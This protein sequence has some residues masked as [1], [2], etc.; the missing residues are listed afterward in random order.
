MHRGGKGENKRRGKRENSVLEYIIN[1]GRISR[2]TAKYFSIFVTEHRRTTARKKRK[3]AAVKSLSLNGRSLVDHNSQKLALERGVSHGRLPLDEHVDMKTRKVLT[4]DHVSATASGSFCNYLRTFLQSLLRKQTHSLKELSTGDIERRS[5]AINQEIFAAFDERLQATKTK[6]KELLSS[7]LQLNSENGDSPGP[8]SDSPVTAEFFAALERAQQIHQK[9]RQLL[10]YA[11]QTT[12]L[13]IMEQMS[14]YQEA[15]LERLYRWTQAQCRNTEASESNQL[16]TKAIGWLQDRPVLLKYVVDEYCTA[17]R[18]I[19]VRSFLD[20]LTG[21]GS[22]GSRPMELH[23]HDPPRY[24]GDMLAWLHQMVPTEK[25]NVVALLKGCDKSDVSEL[26]ASTLSS[27]TEGVC[28]PLRVRVEQVISSETNA[29]VLHTLSSLLSFYHKT[30][31]Q[32]MTEGS[33]METLCDLQTQ[34]H[35]AFLSA[36]EMSVHRI[37]ERMQSPAQDLGPSPCIGQ[38]LNL[39]RDILTEKRIVE[40]QAKEVGE[41]V[42]RILNP[43]LETLTESASR[44]PR[45]DQATYML[46]SL[47]QIHSSLAM[48]EFVD[49]RI[50]SLK[51]MID[52]N[53]AILCGEQ[54]SSLIHSLGLGPICS[55]LQTRAGEPLANVPGMDPDSLTSFL[56]KFDGLLAAPDILQLSQWRLLISGNHRK[57]VQRR[58]LDAVLNV[59]R[60]LYQAVHDPAN[61]YPNPALL[62]SR[63]PAQVEALLS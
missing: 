35:R 21:G 19:V 50:E 57:L 22:Y 42:D 53:L 38:M 25:E 52:D 58:A 17:R 5:L 20:A 32:V 4:I 18:A 44:I 12:A 62:M 13:N 51:G 27:I 10:Q 45:V 7:M 3:N 14:L 9:C 56:M 23:A 16:L 36:L 61:N 24:V 55:L 46:N 15:A 31:N 40:I 6:T 33:L 11:P 43:L 28:R 37:M 59:Y 34:C 49:Q 29:A 54:A 48:Y 63:T 60:Q 26:V 47:Q 41:I 30:I 39:L 8:S 2:D 1:S